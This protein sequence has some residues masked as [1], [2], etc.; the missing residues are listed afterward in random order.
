MCCPPPPERSRC[1]C[2]NGKAD[3]TVDLDAIFP[4]TE[5]S[6][7]KMI[8]PCVTLASLSRKLPSPKCACNTSKITCH[9]TVHIG[10]CTS[11]KKYAWRKYWRIECEREPQLTAPGTSLSPS[12]GSGEKLT[13]HDN[14]RMPKHGLGQMSCERK[15]SSEF[16]LW[17]LGWTCVPSAC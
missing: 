9:P 1:G 12:V 16:V 13:K 3:E 8:S 4:T 5:P 11:I 7:T 10:L 6:T 2:C 17:R 15:Q 14:N